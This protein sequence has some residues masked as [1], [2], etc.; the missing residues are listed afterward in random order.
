M[1]EACLE[2]QYGLPDSTMRP[3]EVASKA[4][5]DNPWMNITPRMAYTSCTRL[6]DCGFLVRVAHPNASYRV[7]PDQMVLYGYDRVTYDPE[8]MIAAQ[9]RFLTSQVA[10]VWVT[11][12]GDVL[13]QA[14]IGEMM[15]YCGANLTPPTFTGQPVR[16]IW[17]DDT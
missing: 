6:A 16:L 8:A 4:M 12:E 9:S 11:L 17:P 14:S 1:L 3:T 7:H 15:L 10:P 5:V 13:R 2:M